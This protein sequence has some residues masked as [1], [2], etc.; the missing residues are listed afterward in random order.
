MEP[1]L[2][3]KSTFSITPCHLLM[4]HCSLIHWKILIKFHSH[5]E[6]VGEDLPSIYAEWLFLQEHEKEKGAESQ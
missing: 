4:Y 1:A 3:P 5:N 6:K 2:N